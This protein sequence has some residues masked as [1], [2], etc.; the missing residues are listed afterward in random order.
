VT[1][2]NLLSQHPFPY[3]VFPSIPAALSWEPMAPPGLSHSPMSASRAIRSMRA[4]RLP[5]AS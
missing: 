5:I 3:R 4:E 1:G 2:L